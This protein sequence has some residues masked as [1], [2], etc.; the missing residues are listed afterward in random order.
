MAGKCGALLPLCF[1]MINVDDRGSWVAGHARQHARQ[2]ALQISQS[3][4]YETKTLESGPI[5]DNCDGTN[6]QQ[7][8]SALGVNESKFGSSSI[9]LNLTSTR[10]SHQA[11]LAAYSPKWYLEILPNTD[12]SFVIALMQTDSY[13]LCVRPKFSFDCDRESV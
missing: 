13:M 2:L 12:F 9:A 3:A 5:I 10:L 7:N 6:S 8:S 4:G 11:A 1:R